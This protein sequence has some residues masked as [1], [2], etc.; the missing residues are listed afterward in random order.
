MDE[1][2][3]TDGGAGIWRADPWPL[4]ALGL[5]AALLVRACV[6]THGQASPAG[7]VPVFDSSLA[8]QVDNSHAMAALEALPP[9]SGPDRALE[10]MNLAVV[11]FAAGSTEIP[12]SSGAVLQ[13]IALAMAGRPESERYRVCGHTDGALS[14]LADI[15]LSRR[16][17]QAVVDFLAAQGIARGRLQALGA[18]D[19]RPL[20]AQAT[21]EARFRNRRIEF[22]LLP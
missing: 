2:D 14:P 20:V 4:L 6:P 10:A 5:I 15:E 17:A 22:T 1:P 19:E 9:A 8:T 7:A 3:R 12:E 13:R 21:E 16:R 11:D 18:G